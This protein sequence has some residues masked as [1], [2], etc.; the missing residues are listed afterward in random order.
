MLL[1]L[2]SICSN[3]LEK[4]LGPV[5]L[6]S[7]DNSFDREFLENG[8]KFWDHTQ[9]HS[10]FYFYLLLKVICRGIFALFFFNDSETYFYVS[11]DHVS[12]IDFS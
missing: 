3:A 5:L 8:M 4:D 11:L 7:R 10:L 1:L 6:R 9:F 2:T 12:P